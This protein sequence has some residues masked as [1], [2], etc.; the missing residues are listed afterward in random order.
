MRLIISLVSKYFHKN[1]AVFID[2]IQKQINIKAYCRHFQI[3]KT[4]K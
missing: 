1:D 2:S 4:R 3:N